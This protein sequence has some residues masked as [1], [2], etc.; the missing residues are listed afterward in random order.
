VNFLTIG[1]APLAALTSHFLN[2]RATE[3]FS[4]RIFDFFLLIDLLSFYGGDG[5]FL[6]T[7][8]SGKARKINVFA[9][10]SR[11]ETVRSCGRIFVRQP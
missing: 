6:F 1:Y 10:K 11:F 9:A 3:Q 5:V 2:R 8:F 4:F 7:L